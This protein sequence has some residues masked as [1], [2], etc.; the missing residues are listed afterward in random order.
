MGRRDADEI[1][2]LCRQVRATNRQ[3]FNNLIRDL[4]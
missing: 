2:S 1:V 4:S 3:I